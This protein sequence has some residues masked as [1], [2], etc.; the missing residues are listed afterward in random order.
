MG[1]VANF[2]FEEY[3]SFK[4]EATNDVSPS[5]FLPKMH[6]G[7]MHWTKQLKQHSPAQH[8]EHGA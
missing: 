6:Q 5:C 1:I 4:F 2:E 8:E 3:L 7:L